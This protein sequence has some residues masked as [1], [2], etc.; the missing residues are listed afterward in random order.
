MFASPAPV[1][2]RSLA[3]GYTT[4]QNALTTSHVRTGC[5]HASQV[6]SELTIFCPLQ[7]PSSVSMSRSASRGG[8]NQ[9]HTTSTTPGSV[10]YPMQR[11]TSSTLA[12]IGLAIRPSPSLSSYGVYSS[13]SRGYPFPTMTSSPIYSLPMSRGASGTSHYGLMEGAF[14]N[15]NIAH[16]TTHCA[17]TLSPFDAPVAPGRYTRDHTPASAPLLLSVSRHFPVLS[18]SS[19]LP[20]PS[21]DTTRPLPVSVP[22]Q[23]LRSILKKPGGRSPSLIPGTASIALDS[24]PMLTAPSIPK[25]TTFSNE[26]TE[27]GLTSSAREESCIAYRSCRGRPPTPLPE[28]MES[29]GE[30]TD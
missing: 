9:Y 17:S 18:E 3:R 5:F 25:R 28:M 21:F 15:L 30:A 6:D 2:K 1:V 12:E 13:P 29:E 26:T 27:I 20:S 11:T 10:S 19:P 4:A 7:A 8:S 23:R 22:P 14:E 16:G 24:T